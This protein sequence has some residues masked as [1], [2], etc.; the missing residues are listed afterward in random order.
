MHKTYAPNLKLAL[1]HP[2]ADLLLAAVAEVPVVPV[3]E[4][5]PVAPLPVVEPMAD[6]PAADVVPLPVVGRAV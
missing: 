4:V 6:L 1:V 3:V 2:E 5:V